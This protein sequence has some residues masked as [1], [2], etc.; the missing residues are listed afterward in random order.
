MEEI[1]KE[2]KEKTI[3]NKW[4]K[5][6]GRGS[7][8]V[9]LTFES[10]LQKETE[11]FEIPDYKGIELKTKCSKKEN[12]IT[13]FSATPDSYLFQIKRLQ[14]KYGYPDSELPEFNV[15]NLSIY[16]NR[17]IRLN[18]HYFRLHVDYSRKKVILRI[19]D[20][21]GNIIDDITSWS[22][23]LLKEKLE[24]KL[25]YLAFIS[26]DR[27]FENNT[28]YFRYND[29]KFYKLKTFDNFLWLIDHGMIKVTFRIGIHKNERRYGEIYDHGTSFCI[30]K[31]D[32]D[33]LFTE[34]N[35]CDQE[36]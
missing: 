32:I 30:G 25:T 7:S 20:K 18:N 12:F 23:D 21:I 2:I 3:N 16:G 4:I 26:A 33:R 28:V 31:Y 9:G 19:Y 1:F 35:I 17:K 29:I 15:F 22:F 13:L 10:L 27:K 24:R 34:I 8:A 11:N 5:S 14:S 6:K 36:N